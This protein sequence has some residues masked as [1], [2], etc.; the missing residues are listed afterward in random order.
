[1]KRIILTIS[2]YVIFSSISYIYKP[3]SAIAFIPYESTQNVEEIIDKLIKFT[4]INNSES[5][6]KKN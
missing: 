2:L 4:P 6:E 1:M 3:T 5:Y